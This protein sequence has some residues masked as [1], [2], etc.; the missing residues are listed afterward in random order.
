MSFQAEVIS[1]SIVNNAKLS[2]AK[3]Q[4]QRIVKLPTFTVGK[5]FKKLEFFGRGSVGIAESY[6]TSGRQ[7]GT[8]LFHTVD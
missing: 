2:R 7:L 1:L 3:H 6:L 5:F 4:M 8:T